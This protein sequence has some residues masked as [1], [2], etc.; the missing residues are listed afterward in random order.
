MISAGFEQAVSRLVTHARLMER[1]LHDPG[2]WSA[3]VFGCHVI[4]IPLERHER[5]DDRIVLTG[6]LR[7]ACSGIRYV[8]IWCGRDL[9]AGWPAA[10]EDAPVRITLDLGIENARMAS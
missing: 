2:P 7:E 9:V 6:Y 3:V 5:P 8:E 10:G 1:A 4:W